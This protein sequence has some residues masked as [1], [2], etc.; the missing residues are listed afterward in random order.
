MPTISKADTIMVAANELT[1]VLRDETK[2]KIGAMEQ[3]QLKQLAQVFQKVA[4]TLNKK[5]VEKTSQIIGNANTPAR[6]D[7]T[8]TKH[9]MNQQQRNRL[10]PLLWE[11]TTI[12]LNTSDKVV[13]SP[14]TANQSPKIISQKENEQEEDNTHP[15][16][17]TRAK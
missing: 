13:A 3:Q 1:Q 6:E 4:K 2:S 10:E 5:E 7:M 11:L 15:A 14:T 9:V 16:D 17:N 12:R 8:K